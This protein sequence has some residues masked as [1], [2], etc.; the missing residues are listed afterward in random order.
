MSLALLFPGQGS[1]RCGM[2]GELPGS[3]AAQA[4][5]DEARAWLDDHALPA[6]LDDEAV[7]RDTTATQIALLIT[8]VACART[9]GDDYALRPQVVAGHSVGAFAAAVCAG[10]LT[11][12]EALAAVVLRGELMSAACAH[13]EWG[14]AAVI[15]LPT[16]AVG[17]LADR[18]H[19]ELWVANVNTATQTV[20]AGSLSAL[21]AAAGAA[22][23]AGAA[24]FT[25]L[26]VVVA[27]HCPVQSDTARRMAEH[28]SRLPRRI[29]SARYLTN[30]GGR[31][32]RTADAVLD[33]LSE[34]VARPV[35]WY[36]AT[37][38][39]PELGVTCAVEVLPGHVLTRL[40]AVNAPSVLSLSLSDNGFERTSTLVRRMRD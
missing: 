28:L 3:A 21:R 10:V 22:Q 33:D 29:P 30:T 27:S 25:M 23:A 17:R 11:L 13:G 24:D 4:V 39:A 26:D 35:Q 7:L 5:L 14:M 18:L 19:T 15:G 31:A 6:N 34:S 9:L 1:Q 12:P 20:L 32:V 38:L 2:L 36:D 37:R 8:G 16:R 40:N